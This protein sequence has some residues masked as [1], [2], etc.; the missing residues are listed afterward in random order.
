MTLLHAISPGILVVL[1]LWVLWYLLDPPL[2]PEGLSWT[3]LILWL[4][5]P[6]GMYVVLARHS[7]PP[8]PTASPVGEEGTIA[9][10]SPLQVE[11]FGSFWPARCRAARDLRLGDR[12]R[13]VEREGLTLVVERDS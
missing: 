8:G 1:V 6:L 7:Y 9:R 5:A 2:R 4:L 10:L 11:V 13:V 12:V 3:R